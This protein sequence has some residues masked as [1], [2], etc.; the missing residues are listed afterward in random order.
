MLSEIS[1]RTV[2]ALQSRQTLVVPVGQVG[3]HRE[4]LEVPGTERA[5]FVDP[6]ENRTVVGPGATTVGIAG[7]LQLVFDHETKLPA[8]PVALHRV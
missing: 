5:F 2:A 8:D 7:P 1:V 3:G 4:S 6:R